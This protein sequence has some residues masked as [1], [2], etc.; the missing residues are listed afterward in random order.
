[1]KNL[2]GETNSKEE[3]PNSK[4]NQTP[5]KGGV[6]TEL[7]NLRN[8]LYGDQ[9]KVT[10]ERLGDLSSR[11]D[12]LQKELTSQ[13]RNGLQELQTNT[14]AQIVNLRKE[15]GEEIATQSDQNASNQQTL[16]RKQ[17][18][19][20]NKQDKS[21]RT[22]LRSLQKNLT[23]KID[24]LSNQLQTKTTSLEKSLSTHI[25]HQK[26]EHEKMLNTLEANSQKEFDELKKDLMALASRLETN[27]ASR[28]DLSTLL[29]EL[30]HRLQK[31]E[32]D[33]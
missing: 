16:K 7:D 18:E 33:N 26:D 17:D 4:E 3:A 24:S 32:A 31:P 29:I 9:V 8:I 14:D 21:Q 22:E 25:K 1:M 23:E 20:L 15:L 28:T 30:G 10:E 13:I 27:K 19:K 12:R 6:V 2:T 5:K 11:V